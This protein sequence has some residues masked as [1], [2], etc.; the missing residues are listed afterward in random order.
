MKN[1]STVTNKLTKNFNMDIEDI[2]IDFVHMGIYKVEDIL[3]YGFNKE[4]AV[5]IQKEIS[6]K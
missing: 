6:K 1:T 4:E 3:N 5:A 2:A